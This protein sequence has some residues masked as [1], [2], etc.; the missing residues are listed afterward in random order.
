[1]ATQTFACHPNARPCTVVGS[2]FRQMVFCLTLHAHEF[3]FRDLQLNV[4]NKQTLEGIPAMHLLLEPD[5]MCNR[6]RLRFCGL[7]A[8]RFWSLSPAK[9][10]LRTTSADWCSAAHRRLGLLRLASSHVTCA[11]ANNSGALHRHLCEEI[12]NSAGQAVNI[13]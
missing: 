7:G 5:D 1:M 8:G 2:P 3:Y 11:L 9:L 13:S 6:V 4:S 12:S 10:A